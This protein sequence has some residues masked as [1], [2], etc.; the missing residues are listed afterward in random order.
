MSTFRPAPETAP[1]APLRVLLVDDDDRVRAAYGRELTLAG[2]EVVP[3]ASGEAAVRLLE[4]QPFDVVVSDVMMPGM[5]GVD[6]LRAVRARDLDVPV[7]LMTGAPMVESAAQ[8]VE[9]GA[10]RYLIKPM[11][12]GELSAAAKRAGQMARVGRAERAAQSLGGEIR[13]L[14]ADRAGLEASFERALEALVIHF[15]PIVSMRSRSI[16]A[17]EALLRSKEPVLST[18]PLLLDAAERLGHVHRLG[19]TIRAKVADELARAPQPVRAFV[20]LHPSDLLDEALFDPASALAAFAPRV[21]LEVT[22]RH[23]LEDVPNLPQR[24]TRLRALGYRIAV[25]DLG[26]GY[27]G[28]ASFAQLEP[29]VVKL[30]MALVRGVDQAP[31]KAK[32]VGSMITLCR[33]LGLEVICEG[34]ETPA[35]RDALVQLGGDLLQ[36]Y[37]FARPGLPFPVV[38]FEG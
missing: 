23:A 8:A 9:Y 38:A 10:L 19:Q 24:I 37:L 18:P 29:Q 36:G 3:A 13:K 28:L 34:V 27:A 25:D 16:V 22:E 12:V 20:N 30:D 5:S 21:V 33:D 17:Y 4:Q 7:L 2:L 35:E 32:L 6:L 14:A 15:Q 31:T 1:D 26:A 11:M